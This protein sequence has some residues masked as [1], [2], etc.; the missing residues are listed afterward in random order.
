MVSRFT[1]KKLGYAILF[2]VH[3]ILD[4]ILLFHRIQKYP[5]SPSTHY[6]IRC[7]LIFSTLESWL[8]NMGIRRRMRCGRKPYPERKS[9]GLKVTANICSFWQN[10]MFTVHEVKPSF[11][12]NNK[13]IYLQNKKIFKK[14]PLFF[15]AASFQLLKLENL[16]RWSFFTLIYNRTSNIWIISYILHIIALFTGD[17]NSINWP[18]SQ[19]VA[20]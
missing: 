3:K 14:K 13:F 4:A 18:R 9:C 6:R 17:M 2:I 8:K 12:L 10:Q 1:Y 7:G 20:S 16:L 5:D 15:S 11:P 19:C